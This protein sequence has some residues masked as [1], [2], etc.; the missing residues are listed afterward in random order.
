MEVASM[1][2]GEPF[3]DEPDCVCPVIAEFLR[4]YNDEI[5]ARRRQD[6][7]PYASLVVQTRAGPST[8]RKR[9]NQCL[10]WRL[11]ASGTRRRGLRR[12]AWMFPLSS[13]ARDIEIAHRTA[14]WAAASPS[15]H[16]STLELIEALAGR[17]PVVIGPPISLRAPCAPSKSP[18]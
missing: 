9:A 14:R 15:R 3:S 5:D 11:K 18:V 8:E 4:T 7:Y 2:A 1:L 6:L 10:D 12:V 17:K 16:A 13:A